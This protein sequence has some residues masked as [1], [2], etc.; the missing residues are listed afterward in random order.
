MSI[1]ALFTVA[2]IWKWS[3]DGWVD[4]EVGVQI[5]NGILPSHKKEC[6]FAICSNMDGFVGHYAKWNTLDRER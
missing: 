4:K 3:I 1:A 2:K 6:S 5:Y